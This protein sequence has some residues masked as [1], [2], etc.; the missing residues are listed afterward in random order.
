M[1]DI[2]LGD[3]IALILRDL[4]DTVEQAAERTTPLGLRVDDVDLEIPAYLHVED[5]EATA[6]D[7]LRLR[8]A[9]PT[10]RETLPAGRLGRVRIAITAQRDEPPQGELPEGEPSEGEP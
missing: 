1:A 6:P 3:L 8:V 7:A 9:L 4:A 10:A 2:T 5:G